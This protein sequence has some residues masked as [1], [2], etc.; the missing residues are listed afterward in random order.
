MHVYRTIN[1]AQPARLPRADVLQFDGTMKDAHDSVKMINKFLWSVIRV[2]LIDVPTDK[3][4]ILTLL[5]G[6]ED[7][8]A[9][10]TWKLTSRGGLE[11]CANGE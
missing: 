2:E 4:G 1:T 10:R 9:I 3:T 5:N 6:F 8:K 11:D 7:F